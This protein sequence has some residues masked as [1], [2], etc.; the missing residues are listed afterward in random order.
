MDVYTQVQ[1][2]YGSCWTSHGTDKLLLTFID[3]FV[4]AEWSPTTTITNSHTAVPCLS[5]NMSQ[6]QA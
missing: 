5:T 6:V 4:W 3:R 2:S 1:V